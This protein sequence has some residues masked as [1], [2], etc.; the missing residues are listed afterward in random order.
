MLL[1]QECGN[2]CMWWS[3]LKEAMRRTHTFRIDTND[4]PVW[5]V[6]AHVHMSCIRTM[7]VVLCMMLCCVVTN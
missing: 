7:L 2:T 6:T 1:P 3:V 5:V 4:R